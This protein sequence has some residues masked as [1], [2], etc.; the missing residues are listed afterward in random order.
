M[1]RRYLTEEEIRVAAEEFCDD[2]D[3]EFEVNDNNISDNEN[4]IEVFKI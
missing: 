1:P 3:I 4:L 2:S